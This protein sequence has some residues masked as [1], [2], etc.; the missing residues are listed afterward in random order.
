MCIC[1]HV[2]MS[3]CILCTMYVRILYISVDLWMLLLSWRSLCTL[4]RQMMY[5]EAPCCTK[6]SVSYDLYRSIEAEYH[7][8]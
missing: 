4:L 2:C 5:L 3:V 8:A 1:M 7:V 6:H